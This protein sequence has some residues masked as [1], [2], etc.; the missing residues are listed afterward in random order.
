M[1][2]VY[3]STCY[4]S[5][6]LWFNVNHRRLYLHNVFLPV[7]FIFINA[8]TVFIIMIPPAI[9]SLYIKCMKV[10]RKKSAGCFSKKC[11]ESGYYALSLDIKTTHSTCHDTSEMMSNGGV[12][13]KSVLGKQSNVDFCAWEYVSNCPAYGIVS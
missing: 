12:S 13:L 9:H 8:I 2:L 6:L 4:V 10:P 7:L 5:S 1:Y 11:V 3:L